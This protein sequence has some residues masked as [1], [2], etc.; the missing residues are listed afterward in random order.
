MPGGLEEQSGGIRI[1]P[2]VEG[3]LSAQVLDLGGPQRVRRPCLDRCH[4]RE[5]RVER[6]GIA[7]RPGRRELA[8]RPR[9]GRA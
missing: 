6:A 1:P 5:R 2:L 8:S 4:E 9:P 7:L 3:D